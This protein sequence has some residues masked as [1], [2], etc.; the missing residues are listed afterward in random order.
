MADPKKMV[1]PGQHLT[2]EEE[3]TSG[4]HTFVDDE[5]NVVSTVSGT[6]S[7]DD[8][9]REVNVHPTGKDLQA[10]DVGTIVIGRAALVKDAVVILNI[11]Y[12]EKDGKRRRIHDTSAALGVARV[13]REFIRS[14]H[15][16]FKVGDFVRA[17]VTG[18]TPYSIEVSTN[19]KGLGKILS[20]EDVITKTIMGRETF[21]I[22]EKKTGEE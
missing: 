11:G 1:F 5:G 6:V 21:P 15:D 19:E 20:R 22:Q 9:V 12:A 13:A 10:I 14:L 18:V 17:K 4:A 8:D 3:Y 16:H 2:V 7:F